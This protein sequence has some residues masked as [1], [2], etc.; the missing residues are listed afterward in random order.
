MNARLLVVAAVAAAIGTPALAQAPVKAP[1]YKVEKCYGISKAGK[2]DC[3][4][5]GNPHVDAVRRYL[6]GLPGDA[7][8]EF[9]LAGH[10]VEE[11]DSE[12][13]RIDTH[14]RPVAAEVWQLYRD[15]LNLFGPRPTLIEW[16]ADIPS[17]E[18]L[19]AEAAE[20]DRIRNQVCPNAR[21]A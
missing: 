7:I 8:G 1:E 13:V 12:I 16:D 5:A 17:L 14:S 4:S 6:E 3:A 21:A 15:A 11:V 2:N 18:T 10:V 19:G 20:A 9:H